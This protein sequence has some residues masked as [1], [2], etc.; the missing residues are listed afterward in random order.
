MKTRCDGNFFSFFQKTWT[1]Y[2]DTTVS[3]NHAVILGVIVNSFFGHISKCH[4][5]HTSLLGTKWHFT[6]LGVENS[7]DTLTI[8]VLGYLLLV[9]RYASRHSDTISKLSAWGCLNQWIN[10]YLCLMQLN[11]HAKLIAKAYGKSQSS[12]IK[13]LANPVYPWQEA[14]EIKFITRINGWMEENKFFLAQNLIAL[15]KM[16]SQNGFADNKVGKRWQWRYNLQHTKLH[17]MRL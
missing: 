13:N 1:N 14:I 9:L 7:W 3:R 2:P 10:I 6:G 8:R 12:C 17:W 16:L 15:R 4:T 5:S 11:D